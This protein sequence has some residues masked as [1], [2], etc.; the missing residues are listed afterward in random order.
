MNV[1]DAVMTRRSIRAFQDKPVPKAILERVLETARWTPS[2]GNTQP[3]Q[4][5]VLTGQPL[6]DLI[7]A[8][9]EKVVSRAPLEDEYQIYPVDLA[10]P[11]ETRRVGVGEAMYAA[12]G[13]E[14][15]DKA[16]RW[17]QF[18]HN[19][20]GFDAPVLLLCY[21]KR[22]MGP[23]Q[24]GD[25]GMMLQTIMLLLREEGLDS[26]AQEAWSRFGK[27]IKQA[28]GIDDAE[29]IF[30]SAMAIGY[31]EM[32]AIINNFERQRAPLDEIV[33]WRGF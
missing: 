11:H 26:C 25:M 23:P 10:H 21:C 14:R 24:W 18:A 16:G 15:E 29:F 7:A 19:F 31:A 3:W 2:G 13:V 30:Y 1:T 22:Y 20:R 28:V 9:Q 17:Q 5:M 8:V 27:T 33:E 12:I 32:D 6:Q 4:L